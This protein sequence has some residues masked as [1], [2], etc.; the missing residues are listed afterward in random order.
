MKSID[1]EPPIPLQANVYLGCKQEPETPDKESVIQTSEIFKGFF[2][3]KHAQ[4]AADAV[5]KG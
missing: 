3:N 1:L 4:D 2:M 5:T